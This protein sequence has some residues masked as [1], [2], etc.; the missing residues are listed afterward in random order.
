MATLIGGLGTSHVPSIG[1]ALDKGLR[2]TPD[3][4]PFFDGYGPGHAEAVEKLVTTLLAE[5][6]PPPG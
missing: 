1:A 4:K 2:E 6:S 3:W 5:P